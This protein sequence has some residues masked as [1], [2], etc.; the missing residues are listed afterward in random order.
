MDAEMVSIEKCEGG[1]VLQFVGLRSRFFGSREVSPG[2]F[3]RFAV[4]DAN[5]HGL[6]TG[7][8]LRIKTGIHDH[9]NAVNSKRSRCLP[10]AFCQFGIRSDYL[11]F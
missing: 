6:L 11:R 5:I 7:A 8:G 9:E 2:L 3:P 4:I 1:A 10:R